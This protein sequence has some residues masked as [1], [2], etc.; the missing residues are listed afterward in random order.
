MEK[1]RIQDDLYLAV[2]GE[3]LENLEIPADRPMAG[4]FAQLA[5][6]VE[7][8]MMA[9][10]E[11]ID[12][13]EKK[14]NIKEMAEAIKLYRL[15]KN[16]EKRNSDGI[17]PILPLL[18]TIN[19]L[20]SVSEFN[21]LLPEFLFKRVE[22]PFQA[23]VTEDMKDATKKSFII[24]G[25]NIILPDTSYYAEGGPYPQMIGLWQQMA[26][27]VLQHT[28]LSLEEQQLFI[29]DT[30]AFDKLVSKSVKSQLEW[31]DYVNNYN[32]ISLDEAVGYLAPIDFENLLKSLYQDNLPKQVIA[33]DLRAI[34]EFNQYFNEENF[35]MFKHW[36]YVKTLLHSTDY[37]SCELAAAGHM[38]TQALM[39][40]TKDPEIEKQAYR[41]ASSVFSEP[42]GIYYGRTYFGEEAKKDVVELVKEIIE[43]YK[44]RM[45]KND[46]LKEAT[47]EKAIKKLSTIEIKMGYPDKVREIYT[48]LIVDE[49]KSYYENMIN[50][51][52]IKDM[53][54]FNDLLKPVDRSIW[55]M[56]GHMVNACYNP[57]ANDITFPAAILQAPFYSIKQTRSENLGGIGSV[58]GHEI[59][60]A[61]D[62]N[63]AH[64]D[65]TGS[66]NNWWTEEDFS[67]FKQKTQDM[68]E[69]FDGI[70]YH[71]GKV[72]GE[73]VVSENIADNG[74]VGVTLEIMHNTKGADFKEFFI[75][76]AR[77]W[78]MK[79]K[80]EYI[81]ILLV[82]DVHSPNV[83][84][85]NMAP[86]NFNEWYEAFDV[87]EKDQ[88]YIAPEKR[89]SIW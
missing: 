39:G 12:K 27:M 48:K 53:D 29:Q 6:D 73:L 32:P 15:A 21:K 85:A 31:A 82:R 50:I 30:I 44:I 17:K 79:A 72:N 83:L 52:R 10:L 19:N 71:G 34:K 84:R 58:I 35:T 54:E 28:P 77:I 7:K 38:F 26:S 61:F 11:A 13:G 78:C 8:L 81:Q 59:S 60:H 24:L 51:N 47:K 4:G 64:F 36:C 62:N 46:F 65:E 33:Y 86:R 76:W 5:D 18:D 80:E 14:T 2:N 89:I 66:L 70:D 87:T 22:L 3:T 67:A 9:D 55:V 88:M 43:T 69:Q 75:N 16:S 40:I 57:S 20:K 25:P 41:V 63:G 1:V 42:L 68:I 49:N 45:A 23:G 56:P 74:G 37:L